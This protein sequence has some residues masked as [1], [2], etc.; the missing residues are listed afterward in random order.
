MV[1]CSLVKTSKETI[2]RQEK[3]VCTSSRRGG[4]EVKKYISNGCYALYL[5]PLK[6]HLL[7]TNENKDHG[8]YYRKIRNDKRHSVTWYKPRKLSAR[9]ASDR[10]EK[11]LHIPSLNICSDMNMK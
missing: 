8:R 7:I 2:G 4:C 10:F 11:R 3:L 9:I 1:N 6:S 5:I